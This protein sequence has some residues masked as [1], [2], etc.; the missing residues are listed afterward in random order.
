MG[1]S[2]SGDVT[3][4]DI[5]GADNV[6]VGKNNRQQ[7]GG[8]GDQTF[9]FNSAHDDGGET[10]T[11][12]LIYE[13]V[14]RLE[15]KLEREGKEWRAAFEGLRHDIGEVARVTHETK[16]RVD[17][18][19]DNVA[20]A[21]ILNQTHRRTFLAGF[22]LLSVPVPLYFDGFLRAI[23]LNWPLALMLALACYAMSAGFWHYMWWGGRL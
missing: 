19:G 15:N 7:T 23:D 20:Q 1:D 14:S 6:A 11:I 10:G 13:L 22:V 12:R 9:T 4:A 17:N 5:D 16:A 8:Y 3:G 21:V 18:I 2:H